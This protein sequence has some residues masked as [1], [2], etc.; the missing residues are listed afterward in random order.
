[1]KTCGGCTACCTILPI[2]EIGKAAHHV[3]R[4]QR[5]ALN[6][7]GPGCATYETRPSSCRGWSCVWLTDEGLSDALRPDRCG[8]VF[9]PVLDLVRQDGKEKPCGQV[10]A[11]KGYEMA[12]VLNPVVEQA[13]I[14]F[15]DQVP[16]VLW[17]LPD[18]TARAIG[19]GEDGTLGYG[20]VMAC[21]DTL[22]SDHERHVRVDAIMASK[23]RRKRA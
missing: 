21:T 9:D 11:G 12:F 4:F 5:D 20:P 2:P 14:M 22:G 10:W 6:I 18:G 3:C 13:I 1:M 19:R 23:R 15:L 17:R 16:I 7:A 8:V